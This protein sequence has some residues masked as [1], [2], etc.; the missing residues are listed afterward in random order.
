MESSESEDDQTKHGSNGVTPDAATEDIDAMDVETPEACEYLDP[1]GIRLGP[2]Q[3]KKSSENEDVIVCISDSDSEP[4]TPEDEF[5]TSD[6][7]E[8]EEEIEA[9]STPESETSTP[10]DEFSTSDQVEG[11]EEIEAESTPESETSTPE[12]EFSE[13]DQVEGEEEIEAESTPESETST[14]EDEFSKS[15]QVEGAEEN[16]AESTPASESETSKAKGEFSKSGKN[17][18]NRSLANLVDPTDSYRFLLPLPPLIRR[19]R[20]TN[21]P[22]ANNK[23]LNLPLPP[24]TLANRIPLPVVHSEVDSPEEQPLEK[25][26]HHIFE[27]SDDDDL[28]KPATLDGLSFDLTGD[29][30]DEESNSF[31]VDKNTDNLQSGVASEQV[32]APNENDESMSEPLIEGNVGAVESQLPRQSD[33][34]TGNNDNASQSMTNSE[35][36]AAP[37]ED[38][39]SMSEPIIE[40]SVTGAECQLPCRQS[41]KPTGNN[42]DASQL[43]S[44]IL[45]PSGEG[46][47]TSLT[48]NQRH[49]QPTNTS[50]SLFR[51]APLIHPYISTLFRRTAPGLPNFRVNQTHYLDRILSAV[52]PNDHNE[53]VYTRVPGGFEYTRLLQLF[54]RKKKTKRI[55]SASNRRD[56]MLKSPFYEGRTRYGGAS[57]VRSNS[58]NQLFQR[59][60]TTR[61]DALPTNAG[62]SQLLTPLMSSTSTSPSTDGTDKWRQLTYPSSYDRP[63]W[64]DSKNRMTRGRVPMTELVIPNVVQ[65]LQYK[66]QLLTKDTSGRSE[67]H[68][69][70]NAVAGKT[71]SPPPPDI[72][73]EVGK[74]DQ[75]ITKIKPAITRTRPSTTTNASD[76]FTPAPRH[77]L[78]NVAL[79]GLTSLPKLD[80]PPEFCFGPGSS[81]PAWKTLSSMNQPARDN[82][83]QHTVC[84]YPIPVIPDG[85]APSSET[86]QFSQPENLGSWA[87]EETYSSISDPPTAFD[88]VAPVPMDISSVSGIV[89]TNAQPDS[90]LSINLPSFA[91]LSRTATGTWECPTCMVF[92]AQSFNRCA[93]CECPQPGTSTMESIQPSAAA[94]APAVDFKTLVS[95]QAANGWECQECFV[96]NAAKEQHCVCCG[97]KPKVL[98]ASQP[99]P[100]AVMN[101]SQPAAKIMPAASDHF[102]ALVHL[103]KSDKWECSTCLTR[104]DIASMRCACCEQPKPS[105]SNQPVMNQLTFGNFPADNLTPQQTN[106]G[107]TSAM[108]TVGAVPDNTTSTVTSA[109]SSEQLLQPKP[110]F[111]NN[112][113]NANQMRTSLPSFATMKGAQ[114]Y[115]GVKPV[116]ISAPAIPNVETGPSKSRSKSIAATCVI[117]RVFRLHQSFSSVI[118]GSRIL[119]LFPKHERKHDV[120]T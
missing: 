30:S 3:P 48:G 52:F 46:A 71:N 10:E 70:P 51:P 45:V 54:S 98:T 36:L 83:Q 110:L 25:K 6:Q 21:T 85:E 75:Q 56:M 20:V 12:D 66:R 50:V 63:T 90:D 35:Q 23:T 34:P 100:L 1:V 19:D 112:S 92:N 78:P 13:S 49:S 16:K 14:P 43:V 120:P 47:S 55:Q 15:D 62:Q 79:Q 9:E 107:N 116:A 8:G 60:L 74:R 86:F 103:Q 26:P 88:F 117:Y 77:E 33:K 53:P 84:M 97:A 24:L 113:I 118:P 59:P 109:A 108:Q 105:T 44:D 76:L 104:N 61:Q 58:D 28:S 73:S 65:L 106:F 93:A 81:Q 80:L 111:D 64:Y 37:N 39:E 29:D 31:L 69:N 5:S 4:S 99:A 2:K 41:D 89:E 57:A 114:K 87:T 38:D 11:E 22:M 94:P 95:T 18:V 115:E 101:Q 72:A 7:V 17:L 32:A 82:M 42:H 96:R 119:P 27:I 91:Q 40:A 68:Q 67:E 102:K